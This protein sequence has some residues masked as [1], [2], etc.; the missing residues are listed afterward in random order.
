M[1]WRVTQIAWK[2]SKYGVFS[3]PYFPVFGLNT[4]I[5]GV[6]L[7]ILPEYRKIRTR[8]TSIFGHYLRSVIH[9]SY[10][11]ATSRMSCMIVP[12][13][14][15]ESKLKNDFWKFLSFIYTKVKAFAGQLRGYY[16]KF[17]FD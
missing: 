13:Y 9:L 4:G 16:R 14:T 8:K 3:G 1:T 10:D 7:C 15:I 5:Y 17:I 6:D 11:W 12:V 2:V